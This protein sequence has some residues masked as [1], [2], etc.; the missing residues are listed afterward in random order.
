MSSYTYELHDVL[1]W[2]RQLLCL[3]AMSYSMLWLALFVIDSLY[4]CAGF[5]LFSTCRQPYSA[6]DPQGHMKNLLY[7]RPLSIKDGLVRH[8][9]HRGISRLNDLTN[10]RDTERIVSESN[11]KVKLM[12]S[13]R[14][15]KARD[16]TQLLLLEGHRLIID[17]L[18]H[19]RVAPEM[20]LY[21][22]RALQAPLG[23]ALQEELLHHR[24]CSHLVSEDVFQSLSETVTS[25][26]VV[27]AFHKPLWSSLTVQGDIANDQ[28]RKLLVV[29][30]G[31]SDPGNDCS[32]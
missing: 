4:L 12:R 22:D 10:S 15:K 16:E 3:C 20:L 27:G 24:G 28:Q 21:T 18:Q 11:A 5:H 25:Q 14:L 30:D 2:R 23:A 29:L 19:G 31:L 9:Y 8:L 1:C 26:G 13:L 32:L 6:N 17:A 7:V